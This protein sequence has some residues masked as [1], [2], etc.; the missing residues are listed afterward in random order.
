MCG[1]DWSDYNEHY[2]VDKIAGGHPRAIGTMTR[3]LEMTRDLGLTSLEDV[4]YHLT[5]MPA[6]VYGLPGI[7]RLEEGMNADV[8]V[9]DYKTVRCNADYVNPFRK[10]DGIHYVLVNGKVAV[11]DGSVTGCLNGRVI[12]RQK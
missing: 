6:K 1:S 5:G 8:T 10:N 9:F 3:R 2:P 12:R 7:G 11:R 4:I